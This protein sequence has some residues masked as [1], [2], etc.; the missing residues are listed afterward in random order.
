MSVTRTETG[1]RSLI[2]TVFIEGDTFITISG[3]SIESWAVAEDKPLQ[4]VMVAMP[5]SLSD[6]KFEKNTPFS[7]SSGW[8]E[9]AQESRQD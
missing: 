6:V 1:T 5:T 9:A 2:F 8:T 4:A 3:F 7:G